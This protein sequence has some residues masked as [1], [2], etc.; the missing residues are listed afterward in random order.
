MSA[1]SPGRLC[2]ILALVIT[3]ATASTATSQMPSGGF[4][5]TDDIAGFQ[6][7][8]NLPVLLSARVDGDSLEIGNL[9]MR[10]AAPAS[11][12][13]ALHAM[14]AE[15]MWTYQAEIGGVPVADLAERFLSAVISAKGPLTVR[16]VGRL[17]L[18]GGA[19]AVRQPSIE[20]PVEGFIFFG[21]PGERPGDLDRHAWLFDGGQIF[22]AL[23]GGDLRLW[24]GADDVVLAAGDLAQFAWGQRLFQAHRTSVVMSWDDLMPIA[25]Q[26]AEGRF[27]AV[28]ACPVAASY[29]EAVIAAQARQEAA[30]M[31]IGIPPGARITWAQLLEAN[32][33]DVDPEHPWL[34]ASALQESIDLALAEWETDAGGAPMVI[35]DMF[36]PC[37]FAG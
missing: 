14:G 9:I 29:R 8:A 12:L 17:E 7:G 16:A 13:D 1:G 5:S 32:A 3:L 31:A 30:A 23:D 11:A 26:L 24:D 25:G 37:R 15:Q 27:D 18:E 6:A 33:L 36:D 34:A 2:G 20:L 4:V 21:Q 35:G 22:V 10:H 28:H 19:F